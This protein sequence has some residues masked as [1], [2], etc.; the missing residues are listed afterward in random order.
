MSATVA[1]PA[2]VRM[3]GGQPRTAPGAA[4][5]PNLDTV[6]AIACILLVAFHVVGSNPERGLH[7]DWD[8]PWRQAMQSFEF[9][10][11]PLF[12][13]LSGFL[14]AGRRATAPTLAPVWR[15]RLRRIG[16]P[17]VICTLVTLALRRAFRG[18]TTEVWH[19]LLFSYEHLWFLQ[20]ILVVFALVALWDVLAPPSPRAL[21]AGCLLAAVLAVGAGWVT[22]FLSLNGAMFLLPFFLFGML[23][24]AGPQLWS[25]RRVIAVAAG[26]AAGVL[27]YQQLAI[28]GAVPAITRFNPAA[29]AAGMAS[30][31][32]LL[33]FVPRV[34]LFDRIGFY[35]YTIYLWHPLASA[36]VRRSLVALGVTARPLLFAACLAAGLLLPLLLH[37][38]LLERTGLAPLFTGSRRRTPKEAVADRTPSR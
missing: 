19:A 33:R 29:L 5:P 27:G 8:S 15:A 38:G 10:R 28:H 1:E 35:S 26:V 6:R 13:V 25:E 2:A 37:R 24:R 21:A 3:P 32:L 7:A 22:D 14:Y 23:L 34:E 9:V 11:M 4:V 12:T 30:A 20:A 18:D 31:L 16:V 36:G 17:L